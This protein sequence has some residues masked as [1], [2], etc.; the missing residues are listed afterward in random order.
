MARR[1]FGPINIVVLVLAAA[2]SGAPSEAPRP[3]PTRSTSTAP[4][5]A[6]GL[7]QPRAVH[8]AT[9]LPDGSV[10][11]T[12]G[13]TAPGCG[14]FEDGQDSEIYRPGSGVVSGPRTVTPRASGT[15]TLLHD[16]RV[17]LAGGYPG[18][19]QGPT[20]TLEAYLSDSREFVTVG[21]LTTPRADHTATLMPDGTVVLAGGFDDEGRALDTTE[22]FDPVTDAVVPGRRLS[23]P[24]AAHQAAALGS[25]LLLVGG[26]EGD[27]ALGS[28]DVL[29]GGRWSPGPELGTP[30]V[31]AGLAAVGNDR[32]LVIGGALTTEGHDKLAS[33]EVVD[34]ARSTTTPGPRLSTGEYKLDGA[35]AVLDDGRVV[36]PSGDHLAVFDPD[37]DS[38]T[39]VVDAVL[40][41]RLFRTVT[42]VGPE[43][44]LVA[45]GYDD[46]ITPRTDLTVVRIP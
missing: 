14:G 12:G 25:R 21:T 46:T 20:D 33:T 11:I 40:E 17:L 10:L 42:R 24:R 8:R 7:L 16:G 3:D 22:V 36:L 43:T 4:A 30:R 44:V 37:D 35:V 6:G 15:A 9:A 31:K 1:L 38:L 18:E 23:A 28:T 2:C 39:E 19:G 13:C 32:A 26:T 34:L 41:P 5:D 45:G 29:F 27:A